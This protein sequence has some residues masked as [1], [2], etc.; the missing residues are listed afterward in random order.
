MRRMLTVA[1]R[2]YNA[3]VKS[4]AFLVSL[5][6]MPILMGGGLLVQ[7]LLK[8]QVDTQEKRF[9]IMDRTPEQ[10]LVKALED[11]A[12]VRNA[13]EIFDDTTGK[14]VKPVFS[15]ERVPPA[16]PSE[17]ALS[18]SDLS[19]RSASAMANIFGFLEIGARVFHY[20]A[21]S[22]TETLPAN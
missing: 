10:Q 2:D 16:E 17:T 12:T 4:K 6:I 14:Q 8:D 20:P 22:Q 18:G 5:F 1:R 11:A 13:E 3:A 21:A 7:L 15:L 9:A 19:Y